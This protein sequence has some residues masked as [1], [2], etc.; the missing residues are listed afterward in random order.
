MFKQPADGDDQE[1]VDSS[2]VVVVWPTIL[3]LAPSVKAVLHSSTHTPVT[4]RGLSPLLLGW[5][6]CTSHRHFGP[7]AVLAD[8]FFS[9]AR[10]ELALLP[11]RTSTASHTHSTS[12]T[13][14]SNPLC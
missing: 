12:W 1:V 9:Y 6:L 11:I 13:R 10:S 7:F 8:T 14:Y 3:G 5:T 4:L 2:T